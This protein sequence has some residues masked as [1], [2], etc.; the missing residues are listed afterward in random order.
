MG[1]QLFLRSGRRL[2]LTDMGSLVFRYADEI[3]SVGQELMETIRG[4]PSERP[5]RLVVGVASVLPKLIV[6][7]LIEPTRH[8]EHPVR[9][10]CSE[11]T[12][13][14]L[15][16][17]L[18][19]HNVDVVL[20]DAPIPARISVRAYNHH[21]GRCGVTFMAS[22]ELADRLREGF[23]QSL[24]RAPVLLPTEDAVVRSELDR[25]F[26]RHG[27][28]PLV[29]AEF[30]DSALLKTFG[31][32]GVGFFAIP[33]VI[34]AEVRRQYDVHSVGQTEDIAENFYAIS[35]ERRV[36]HAGVVAICERA[37]SELFRAA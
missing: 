15:L 20:S 13:E 21:L 29:V 28:Q 25:W 4:Q 11:G 27:V 34:T 19:A 33:S 10:M 12:P 8:L 26:H 3:F 17:A 2:V 16:P 9:L 35:M 36:R 7:H 5:L 22:L 24:D 23:P 18:A 30:E 6:H 1:E 32:A 14:N 37:R 31:Q